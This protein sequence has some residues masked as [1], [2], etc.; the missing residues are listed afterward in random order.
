VRLAAGVLLC[1]D[2][3]AVGAVAVLQE[4]VPVQDHNQ[5]WAQLITSGI[6]LAIGGAVIRH[7][8]SFQREYADQRL[9]DQAAIE[10]RFQV[11]RQ[12]MEA[13]TDNRHRENLVTLHTLQS[14]L[15]E[16]RYLLLG[17]QGEGGLI[18]GER[19]N[20]RV[21]HDLTQDL[22]L[23]AHRVQ[24][25]ETY[26]LRISDKVDAPFNPMPEPRRRSTDGHDS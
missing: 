22:T 13:E 18:E 15:G 3:V 26:L 20:R 9:K 5:L 25:M 4:V 8:I 24:H 21:R 1:L 23:L 2:G 17:A 12:A 6:I 16:M 10:H 11:E 14:S 7:L 19:R